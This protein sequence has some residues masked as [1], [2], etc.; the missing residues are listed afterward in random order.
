LRVR[1]VQDYC[2]HVGKN[3][4]LGN[5]PPFVRIPKLKE[6]VS[7]NLA[8]LASLLQGANA[9]EGLRTIFASVVKRVNFASAET[10]DRGK[11]NEY[12]VWCKALYQLPIALATLSLRAREFH[13]E[14][15]Q[16]IQ[17]NVDALTD[18]TLG[19]LLMI[20]A[21]RLPEQLRAEN[22]SPNDV[23]ISYSVI[24][25]G[26]GYWAVANTE[27][28]LVA[29]VLKTSESDTLDRLRQRWV[30]AREIAR[31]PKCA[32]Q[33]RAHLVATTPFVH[34]FFDF[35][36]GD[37]VA[38]LY[39]VLRQP[40]RTNSDVF[41][42][43]TAL[44][45]IG[46]LLRS[47]SD[48]P[49]EGFGEVVRSASVRGGYIVRGKC[50]TAEE[51]FSEHDRIISSASG[52][53]EIRDFL[54]A[55]C[56]IDSKALEVMR[57][58]F[59]DTFLRAERT[60]LTHPDPHFGNFLYNFRTREAT[61]LD[62]ERAVVAPEPVMLGRMLQFTTLCDSNGEFRDALFQQIMRGY[63]PGSTRRET[64]T[65]NARKAAA[66]QQLTLLVRPARSGVTRG[67]HERRLQQVAHK[68]N[69]LVRLVSDFE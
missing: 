57:G 12:Q 23:C 34:A 32:G 1:A 58:W 9:P 62:W 42:Y 11:K 65:S 14:H 44:R 27:R 29:L 22:P 41:R 48:V 37:S 68:V 61:I 4:D 15:S 21:R 54:S 5:L 69:A 63:E 52:R 59:E 35:A 25:Q 19:Y 13:G 50:H 39:Q 53:G 6:H 31:I 56:C 33:P 40:S 60:C 66:V 30:M 17:H 46:I 43:S 3:I 67:S 28:T 45:G 18:K 49:V 2:L 64:P 16:R 26:A 51:F 47:I 36:P 7:N 8:E 10:P 20:A 38:G 55:H 24:G